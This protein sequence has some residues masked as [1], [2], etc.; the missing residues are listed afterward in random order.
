MHGTSSCVAQSLVG[1]ETDWGVL[2]D[3]QFFNVPRLTEIFDKEQAYEL[4]KHAQT[5]KETA[6]R[7]QVCLLA[8]RP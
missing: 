6:A 7:A 3:F 5:Q 1:A 8:Q 4:F 2:Q